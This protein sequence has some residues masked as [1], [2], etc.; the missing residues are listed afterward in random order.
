[1]NDAASK[2]SGDGQSAEHASAKVD[3]PTKVD[4]GRRWLRE[5]GAGLTLAAIWLVA[6]TYFLVTGG[7]ASSSGS[8][9]GCE[10]GSVNA[11][12]AVPTQ[13]A[14]LKVRGTPPSTVPFGRLVTTK[15]R[16]VEFDVVDSKRVLSGGRNL[17]YQVGDFLSSDSRDDLNR[18]AITVTL[19]RTG[20]LATMTVTFDRTRDLG[21]PGTYS[22][23]VSIVDPRV[24]RV[25]VPF[26]LTMSYPA[27]Q[28]V[29]AWFLL[30]LAPATVYLW[31]LRG[32][33][34]SE[35]KLTWKEFHNWLFSRNG[36]LALGAG[37]A[38][39]VAVFVAVYLR[40]DAW[41]GDGPAFLG[42]FT[43]MFTAFAAASAPVTAAGA[44][45]VESRRR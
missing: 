34:R 20:R 12:Q 8:G 41:P 25:D 9:S 4:T 18:C 19:K 6:L 45:T 5:Y 27:W 14:Q 42:L 16:T 30:M 3:K 7:V 22:G 32:S 33:F 44:D 39:A 23:V 38:A 17:S 10:S 31:L 35:G 15:T 21:D 37:F 36:I 40:A 29:V 13:P 28:K 11:Q 2:S 43:A 26:T 1:M 24:S